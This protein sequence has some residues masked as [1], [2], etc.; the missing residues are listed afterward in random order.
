MSSSS[1]VDD[2]PLGSGHR[3]SRTLSLSKCHPPVSLRHVIGSPILRLLR[4]LR[5][6]ETRVFSFIPCPVTGERSS[7][8][9]RRVLYQQP[10]S[11]L[12]VTLSMSSS[13][14]VDGI[15]LGSGSCASRTIPL[16]K[17][18]PP[19]SLRHVI[20]SP[21]LRLLRRL[22]DLETRVF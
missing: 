11:E 9:L 2:I 1:P 19:V 13:S 6:L 5:V 18:C 15:S 3:A 8:V 10:P 7:E 21:N 17:C 12:F 16:L 20:G 14:P 22:R 4:T